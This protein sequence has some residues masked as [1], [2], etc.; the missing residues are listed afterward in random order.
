MKR[1]TAAVLLML[2]CLLLSGCGDSEVQI[3]RRRET[4]ETGIRTADRDSDELLREQLDAPERLTLSLTEH[5]TVISVDADVEVPEVTEAGVKQVKSGYDLEGD[6]ERF[7]RVLCGGQTL[8]TYEEW[9]SIDDALNAA[10]ASDDVAEASDETEAENSAELYSEITEASDISET[11]FG[12]YVTLNGEEY[13]CEFWSMS[14]VSESYIALQS[15][16]LDVEQNL[17]DQSLGYEVDEDCTLAE[18]EERAGELL[19]EMGFS[20]FHCEDQM[21]CVYGDAG[22]ETEL[23]VLKRAW[24]LIYVREAD[25]IPLSYYDGEVWGTLEDGLDEC[26]P[27]ESILLILGSQGVIGYREDNLLSIVGYSQEG[28]FLLPFSEIQSIFESTIQESV[29]SFQNEYGLQISQITID[30]IQF[31]YARVSDTGSDGELLIPV[32]DFYGP[33]DEISEVVDSTDNLGEKSWL[34]VSA[35]D[36]TILERR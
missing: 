16:I 8:K 21:K 34:T 15:G 13:Y 30:H 19:N 18:A 4:E 29:M 1:R 6:R 28:V 22:T 20:D 26:L 32:W 17:S 27:G 14:D 3:V 35:I 5:D 10:E 23:P 25:G 12:G 2:S 9:Y 36:G 31:G 24:A 7:Q 11:S 33:W